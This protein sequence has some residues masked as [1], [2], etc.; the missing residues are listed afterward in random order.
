VA[1]VALRRSGVAVVVLCVAAV[2]ALSGCRGTTEPGRTVH[3]AS[4]SANASPATSGGS[5]DG[6]TAPEVSRRMWDTM[7]SASSMIMDFSAVLRAK[8][9][10]MRI[11]MSNDGKCAGAASQSGWT[12]QII[13]LDDGTAYIK[14]EPAYWAAMGPKGRSIG[15]LAGNRWITFPSS[16]V[17]GRRLAASCDMDSFLAKMK[18]NHDSSTNKGR[19]TLDGQPVVTIR[20]KDASGTSTLSVAAKGKPYLLKVASDDGTQDAVSVRFTDFGAPVHVAAP[21]ANQTIDISAF[22]GGSDLGLNA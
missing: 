8:P 12:M 22:G 1:V 15:Q 16:S 20:Q 3:A 4:K 6:L 7:N 5:L 2:A 14:G 9:V 18:P 11:A 13:R 17:P 19:G 21:P 10:R